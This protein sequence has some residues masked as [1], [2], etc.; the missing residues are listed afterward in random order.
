L[1]LLV[2]VVAA[3]AASAFRTGTVPELRFEPAPS[4]LGR[5]TPV[6]VEMGSSSRGARELVV[7][8]RQGDR[9]HELLRESFDVRPVWAWGNA[10]PGGTFTATVQP[11]DQGFEEGPAMLQAIVD[12]AGTWLFRPTG[13]PVRLEV[14]IVL[15][16]PRLALAEGE[17]AVAQGGA[18]VV[19]YA[20]GPRAVRHGVRVEEIEF[21]GHALPGTEDCFAFFGIPYDKGDPKDVFVFAEDQVGNRV[22]VSFVDRFRR[23]PP[24]RDTIRLSESAVSKLVPRIMA[25]VPS[26]RDRGSLIDNYVQINADLRSQLAERL[27]SIGRD[28]EPSFQWTQPFVQMPAQVVSTFAD[29]RT[30][31]YQG[32][33]IDHQTHLGFDLASVAK[34]PVPAAN[35]GRVVMAEYFGIYG[36]TIIIDHGYG[37]MTLYAHLSQF[38]VGVGDRVERG[39]IIGRTGSTGLA[40]GDHL[41]FTTLL[42]GH[43]VN[44]LE[45]WDGHWIQDRIASKLAPAFEFESGDG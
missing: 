2:L 28:T 17:V 40:L 26:L 12:P 43:P 1:I 36:N 39:Q 31:R 27:L 7:T 19:R 11:R 3:L 30:Y 25:R 6:T 23:R 29:R 21:P 16:P 32:Q 5:A 42:Y 33:T 38:G 22:E 34:A 8:I 41:H 35:R 13:E 24:T 18:E 9:E 20:V 10:M 45:W 4:V 14:P 44:P 37:L 15:T